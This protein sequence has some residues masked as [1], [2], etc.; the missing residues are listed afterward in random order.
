MPPDELFL[1]RCRQRADNIHRITPHTRLAR[2][3]LYI[4]SALRMLG[5][6][7]PWYKHHDCHKSRDNSWTPTCLNVRDGAS[8]SALLC[9]S[10]LRGHFVCSWFSGGMRNCEWDHVQWWALRK[11]QLCVSALFSRAQ[12]Q[13]SMSRAPIQPMQ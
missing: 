12:L 8:R 2:K 3:F 6:A 10:F 13:I 1:E 5:A 7:L 11:W 9:F 4:Y